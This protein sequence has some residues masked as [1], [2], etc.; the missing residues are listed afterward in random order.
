LSSNERILVVDDEDLV[1]DII[2]RCLEAEGH[3]CDIADSAEA[4]LESLEKVDMPWLSQI[5]TCRANPG[6]SFSL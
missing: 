4:A 2:A 3:D 6:L 5:S 1:S